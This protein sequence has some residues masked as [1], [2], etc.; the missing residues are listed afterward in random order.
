MKTSIFF[1]IILFCATQLKAQISNYYLYSFPHQ[2][3]FEPN[4][5]IPFVTFSM[6]QEDDY[7]FIET[8]VCQYKKVR[9]DFCLCWDPEF[10]ITELLEESGSA[11]ENPENQLFEQEYFS[12]FSVDNVWYY[13]DQDLEGG[14]HHF[15]LT[16][17]MAPG[18]PYLTYTNL[19]METIEQNISSKIKIFPNPSKNEINFSEQIKEV[20]VFDLTGKIT[21]Q[22]ET[23]S[24]K[25]DI[26]ILPEG[27]YIIKGYIYNGQFFQG[28]FVK[29]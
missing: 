25:L 12:S 23:L 26:S 29:N 27:N 9:I 5:E 2:E 1:A 6:G 21:L 24:D 20:V 28:K 15:H 3:L 19:L 18:Q 14:E 13:W 8:E 10:H 17:S 22:S 7:T 4:E 11:C 16:G